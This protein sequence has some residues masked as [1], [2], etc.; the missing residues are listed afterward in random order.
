MLFLYLHISDN[1]LSYYYF[2]QCVCVFVC[3]SERMRKKEKE[4]KTLNLCVIIIALCM[5]FFSLISRWILSVLS[6]WCQVAS[7]V[8]VCLNRHETL[9]T[10]YILGTESSYCKVY[11]QKRSLQN[12]EFAGYHICCLRV[13]MLFACRSRALSGLCWEGLFFFLLLHLTTLWCKWKKG[14]LMKKTNFPIISTL[15]FCQM[16][17]SM[18]LDMNYL[19]E[20]LAVRLKEGA[21][22]PL[23]E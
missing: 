22:G 3:V 13:R 14:H 2:K 15:Y 6:P 17:P 19:R 7:G 1:L 21:L 20:W 23:V 18:P 5:F 12:T 4:P 16:E 8:C 11:I 10:S 9:E